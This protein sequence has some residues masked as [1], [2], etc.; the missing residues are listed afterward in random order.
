MHAARLPY[1]HI[2]LIVDVD[3][4]TKVQHYIFFGTIT[5][6]VCKENLFDTQLNKSV[7]RWR[8]EH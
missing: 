2:S 3:D 1:T 4:A 8:R 7:T 6:S 5:K